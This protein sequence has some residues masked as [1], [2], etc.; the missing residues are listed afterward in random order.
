MMRGVAIE[1]GYKLSE[2]ALVRMAGGVEGDAE[3]IAC[4]A[5]VFRLLGLPYRE[6]TE[7]NL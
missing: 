1:K 5:D 2:Y 7:R 3:S 4:E 6:P